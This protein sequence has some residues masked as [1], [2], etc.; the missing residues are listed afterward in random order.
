LHDPEAAKGY[1]KGGA[2]Y[3]G[4]YDQLQND[5][6]HAM[7]SG[8]TVKL[9][10]IRMAISAIKLMEIDK[11]LSKVEDSDVAN[12]IQKQIKQHKDSI[13]Q[14]E[15]GNRKD[16]AD[17]ERAELAVLEAYMPKQMSEE[18]LAALVKEVINDIGAKSKA[19]T[20][21]VMKAV[22]EKAKGR[23]DGKSVSQIVG[24]IL[25]GFTA[26]IMLSASF[27]YATEDSGKKENFGDKTKSF[28]RKL[29]SYPAAVTQGSVDMLADTG[30]RATSVVT[31]EVK[32]VGEVVTGDTDKAK[33]LIV[34]PVIGTAD[35]A[36]KAVEEAGKVPVEAAKE[37]T[38]Q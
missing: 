38:Q 30:K 32:T 28:I 19:D 8:E 33:D 11:K 7:K 16:L 13:E 12:I 21:K 6:K 18:E 14:F 17:K 24:K 20:G 26:I 4:L 27:S 10:V 5:M 29:F 2:A 35:T 36:I 22:L 31:N 15:K 37:N 25:M 3:M 23:A 1:E 9:S 34:A